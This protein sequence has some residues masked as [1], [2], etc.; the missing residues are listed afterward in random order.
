MSGDPNTALGNVIIMSLLCY[1]FL[2]SLGIPYKFIDDGDDCGVFVEK[3]HQH[4]VQKLPEHHLTY[5]FE[6]DVEPPAYAMEHVEFC[7][8][9]PV[10]TG[11][12]WVMIRNPLK[13]L[14]QD[15]MHIDKQFATL[16]QQRT[17]IGICGLSLNRDIPV[18]SALY[19]SMIGDRD[20]VV[21]RLIEERPGDFFNCVGAHH[22]VIPNVDEAVCRASFCFAFGLTPD[23]QIAIESEL[24]GAG[25]TQNILSILSTQKHNTFNY[26]QNHDHGKI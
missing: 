5:G 20:A 17:A 2:E 15:C 7:Q 18:V 12:G 19:E 14:N 1:H 16:S 21:E 4:L 10:N 11:N 22:A 25:F 9:R 6:M 3:C 8:C 24:R 13:A 23:H 26:R